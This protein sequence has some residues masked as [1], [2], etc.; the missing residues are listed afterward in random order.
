[1]KKTTEF[2]KYMVTGIDMR[3]RRFKKTYSKY[4]HAACINLYRGSIWG[5]SQDGKRTL[6]NRVYN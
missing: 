6:L 4:I 5:V 1:M 3:G 2:M